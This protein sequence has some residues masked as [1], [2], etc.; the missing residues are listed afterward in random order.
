MVNLNAEGKQLLM[1]LQ[2]L[3]LALMVELDTMLAN[4]VKDNNRRNLNRNN[5][6][7]IALIIFTK[8]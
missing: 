2:S 8:L 3:Y 6:Y 4:S 5:L 7:N 1:T